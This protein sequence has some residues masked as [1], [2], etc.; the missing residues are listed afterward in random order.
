MP[1][2]AAT[3][4]QMLASGSESNMN[5][6]LESE[7][8]SPDDRSSIGS[9][10]KIAVVIPCFRGI[11]TVCDVIARI[12]E[13]VGHIYL[14]D[15]GCP[16]GS[17]DHVALCCNDPRLQVIHNGRN[18]GVGGA[19]KRGYGRALADGAD[20][21]VKI[22]ADG[23]MDPAFI[24]NLI[25]PIVFGGADYAKGNRFA[26]PHLMPPG[27]RADAI[28]MMP[29]GRRA[30]NM[31]LS[32]VHRGVTGYWR[33]ADPANGYTAIHR[34]AL[35]RIDLE[36]VAD[37]F[38]FETD[39]LFQLNQARATVKDVPLPAHYAGELSSLSVRRI[40]PRFAFMA[41]NRAWQRLVGGLTFRV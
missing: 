41:A 15:D 7:P 2:Q 29:R 34:R 10:L 35:Q 31:L 27:S 12:G 32:L 36:A 5:E 28:S 9:P 17:G 38:F 14:I 20:I 16:D 39:M 3:E 40:A 4:R 26:R 1:G 22:D 6:P 11:P 19:M 33:V 21:V 37:C 24:R 30:A 18:L 8:A 25:E 23:Q 13:F